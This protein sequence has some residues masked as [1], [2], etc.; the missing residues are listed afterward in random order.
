MLT[1]SGDIRM[2]NSVGFLSHSRKTEACQDKGN[3]PYPIF[4]VCSSLVQGFGY[5]I[6]SF[7]VLSMTYIIG[8]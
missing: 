8:R 4:S 3:S 5:F 7:R 6:N 1:F 2:E